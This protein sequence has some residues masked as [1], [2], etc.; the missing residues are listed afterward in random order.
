M[1]WPSFLWPLCVVT[2]AAG[3]NGAR[4]RPSVGRDGLLLASGAAA[5]GGTGT[6][7][8]ALSTGSRTTAA[9]GL[10]RPSRSCWPGF[11]GCRESCG[12]RPFLRCGRWLFLRPVAAHKDAAGSAEQAKTSRQERI[13]AAGNVPETGTWLLMPRAVGSWPYNAS[14]QPRAVAA[15]PLAPISSKARTES[16]SRR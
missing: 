2:A 7:Y 6:A 4:S 1:R 8:L 5:V 11:A 9:A 3:W 16:A 12:L 13:L 14:N 10:H 15:A